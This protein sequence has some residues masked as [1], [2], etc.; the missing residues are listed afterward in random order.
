MVLITCYDYY[1]SD[2]REESDLVTEEKDRGPDEESSLASVCHTVSHWANV[3]HQI[4]GC[5]GL[6]VE[7]YSIK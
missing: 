1:C 2:A 3:V 6:T 5:D 7:E 4:V